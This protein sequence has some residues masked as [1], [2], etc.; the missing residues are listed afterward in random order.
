MSYNNK[1]RSRI[2]ELKRIEAECGDIIKELS[3]GRAVPDK[4]QK[5][6][7]LRQIIIDSRIE[8]VEK[9]KNG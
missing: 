2:L 7:K 8:R 5:I 4:D 6:D 3:S 9:E 1:H